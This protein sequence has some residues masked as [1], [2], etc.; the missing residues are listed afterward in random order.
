MEEALH[1]GGNAIIYAFPK[2]NGALTSINSEIYISNEC[3][4]HTILAIKRRNAIRKAEDEMKLCESQFGSQK[5][6]H[7]NCLYR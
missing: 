1:D 3:D 2:Y 7:P 4:L 6:Q 5:P